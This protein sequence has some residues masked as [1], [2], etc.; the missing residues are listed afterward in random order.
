MAKMKI[1]LNNKFYKKEA[2]E[3]AIAAF[4][5]VCPCRIINCSFEVEINAED[6]AVADEFCNFVLGITK[7]SMLF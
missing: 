6:D 1:N 5:E 4:K 7:D 3:K 2:I